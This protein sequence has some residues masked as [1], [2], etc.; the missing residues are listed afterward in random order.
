ML[1][2]AGDLRGPDLPADGGTPL[3]HRKGETAM[4]SATSRR[5]FM[6]Q[7]AVAGVGFWAA[8]GATA[9]P[10][11]QPGPNERVNVAVIGAGGQGA[12]DTNAVFATQLANIVAL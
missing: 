2:L 9:A 11:R 4:N 6:K 3:L 7:C 5:D 8:G 1:R 10:L 12:G